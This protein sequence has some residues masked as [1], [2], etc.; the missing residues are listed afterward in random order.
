[1]WVQG[2]DHK[3]FLC[4][5]LSVSPPGGKKVPSSL[6]RDLTYMVDL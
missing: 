5:V 3:I 2:F 6:G 4:G 1:M